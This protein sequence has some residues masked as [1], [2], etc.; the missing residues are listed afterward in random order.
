M[1]TRGPALF[2][3]LGLSLLPAN[4][5]PQRRAQ[6][7]PTVLKEPTDWRFERLPMPPPFAPSVKLNGFEE[8]RFAPGM[9]DTSSPNYFTYVLVITADGD[10]GIDRAGIVD[11]LEKYYRGLSVGVGQRKGLKPDPAQIT[12]DLTP[13]EKDRYQGKLV[14]FDTFNDGR[15][16]VLNL[17]A[18]VVARPALKKT[19][20]ILLISPQ[21]P[22][23]AVWQTMH[24]IDVKTAAATP[25]S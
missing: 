4:A 16:I 9:F 18:H 23:T 19:N 15:K 20:L 5:Q 14:Y 2:V 12:A 10:Q 8:A 11:F 1:T 3:L 17:E 24:G 13:G 7:A 21:P 22:D 25:D 6:P